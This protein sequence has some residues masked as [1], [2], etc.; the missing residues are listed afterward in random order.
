MNIRSFGTMKPDIFD[1]LLCC[2]QCKPRETYVKYVT[3]SFLCNN[4]I[5]LAGQ[6][7]MYEMCCSINNINYKDVP[8]SKF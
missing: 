8:I 2:L 3:K 5:E 4:C 6:V 1:H 7:K